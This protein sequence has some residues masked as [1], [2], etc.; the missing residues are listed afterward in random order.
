MVTSVSKKTGKFWEKN[1]VV[2]CD[3]G[4]VGRYKNQHSFGLTNGVYVKLVRELERMG[5]EHGKR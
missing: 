5:C 4:H 3:V 2:G 1:D